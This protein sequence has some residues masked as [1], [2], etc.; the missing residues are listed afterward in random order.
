M[1]LYFERGRFWR[2]MGDAGR[3]YKVITAYAYLLASERYDG[4]VDDGLH[5]YHSVRL[6]L[7]DLQSLI[8]L[9]ASTPRS[10]IPNLELSYRR[11]SAYSAMQ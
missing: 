11:D 6:V 10:T 4:N 1:G 2:A 3:R 9:R 5:N 7:L 8:P